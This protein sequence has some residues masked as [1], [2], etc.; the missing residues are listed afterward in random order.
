MAKET[1]EAIHPE[2]LANM[3]YID[4]GEVLPRRAKPR[5]NVEAREAAGRHGEAYAQANWVDFP[6][7]QGAVTVPRD[8][9]AYV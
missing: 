9:I 5:V 3:N 4:P 7:L 6:N 8:M 2:H 1:S